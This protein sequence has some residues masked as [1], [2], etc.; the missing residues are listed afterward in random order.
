ME[1]FDKRHQLR[2]L[3]D[4]RYDLLPDDDSYGAI[5]V[6]IHGQPGSKESW[7]PVVSRLSGSTRRLLV[8]DRPGWGGNVQDARSIQGNARYVLS[9]LKEIPKDV[10]VVLVG[11][12]LGAAIAVVA[13]TM[14]PTRIRNVIA[15]SP[16]FNSDAIVKLDS[17][18]ALPYIG[19]GASK[20][21]LELYKRQM[22]YSHWGQSSTRSFHLE[23][24]WLLRE[25]RGLDAAA[26]W[27]EGKLNILY[28]LDDVV[29]PLRS[30]VATIKRN[31]QS[32]VEVLRRGGHDLLRTRAS[33]VAYF[34]S[35]VY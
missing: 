8:I 27:F 3:Y 6:F 2:R 12:S 10:P 35:K 32:R 5:V 9:L 4:D 14:E 20:V 1:G 31:P 28:A 21:T 18:I 29:V 33:A 24:S 11:H 30:I 23:Q 16:A 17:F 25:L 34:L 13:G 22:G 19:M 26:T 7:A 15:I